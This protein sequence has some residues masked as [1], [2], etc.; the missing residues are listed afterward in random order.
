MGQITITN[1]QSP[2]RRKDFQTCQTSNGHSQDPAF[3]LSLKLDLS[4]SASAF[5]KKRDPKYKRFSA[6][7]PA[8]PPARASAPTP[9][10]ADKPKRGR[11]AK[12]V[13]EAVAPDPIPVP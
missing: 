10:T 4:E 6:G 13:V 11:P 5:C 3:R 8:G 9:E 2:L 1:Q 7:L 12:P